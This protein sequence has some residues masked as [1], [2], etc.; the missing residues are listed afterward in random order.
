MLF[1]REYRNNGNFALQARLI[2][3]LAFVPLPNLSDSFDAL[4]DHLPEELLPVVNWFETNYMGLR[5][6]R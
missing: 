5:N 4:Y 1:F 3:A 6:R 2:T